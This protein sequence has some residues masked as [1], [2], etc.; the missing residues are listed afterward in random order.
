M[1]A[2]LEV[3][4]AQALAIAKQNQDM[5]DLKQIVHDLASNLHTGLA[6]TSSVAPHVPRDTDLVAKLSQ[7][8]KMFSFDVESDR[9]FSEWF[10]RYNPIIANEGSSLKEETK[11]RLVLEKSK[12]LLMRGLRAK[13]N[14]R[15]P[16]N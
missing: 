7:R 4:Q 1:E 16:V 6:T 5:T 8:I 12:T 3:L 9:S 10:D 14:P 15:N 13:C 2:M 11:V